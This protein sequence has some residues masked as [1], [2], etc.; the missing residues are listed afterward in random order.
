[1]APPHK[2]LDNPTVPQYNGLMMIDI[3]TAMALELIDWIFIIATPIIAVYIL[4]DAITDRS[5]K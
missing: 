1:L 5:E 4:W 3:G 2:P